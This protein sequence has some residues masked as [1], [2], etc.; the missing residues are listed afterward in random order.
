MEIRTTRQELRPS[1]AQPSAPGQ[2]MV[3][4]RRDTGLRPTAD[5]HSIPL[6]TQDQDRTSETCLSSGSDVTRIDRCRYNLHVNFVRHKISVCSGNGINRFAAIRTFLPARREETSGYAGPRGHFF[7]GKP[8]KS[9]CP[10]VS[11][12]ATYVTK[13]RFVRRNNHRTSPHGTP[14]LPG[15][16]TPRTALIQLTG[17]RGSVRL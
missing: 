16:T 14:T 12:R 6:L 10:D 8:A 11:K 4:S 1:A 5:P 15:A 3:D 7:V 9:T 2:D 17:T 13:R